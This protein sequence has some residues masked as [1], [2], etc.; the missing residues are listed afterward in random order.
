MLDLIEK[1]KNEKVQDIANKAV[2][3]AAERLQNITVKTANDKQ[4]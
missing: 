1:L 4:S 2:S 3:G